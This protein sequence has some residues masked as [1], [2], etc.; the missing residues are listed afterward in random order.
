[1]L[2][3]LVNHS[4]P[5]VERVDLDDGTVTRLLRTA[6]GLV[7][8]TVAV[9]DDGVRILGGGDA[10]TTEIVREW[11]DLDTDIDAV[12]EAF[13]GD[14]VLGPL[15][16]ERPA[17]RVIGHP[18]AFEAAVQTVLGQQVSLAACRTFTGRLAAAYGAPGPGEL[19]AFPEAR[20]VADADLDQ[21]RAAVGIPLARARTV[22]AV[23]AAFADGL[24]VRRGEDAATVRSALLALPGIGPWTVDYL[25]LRVLR[26]PD[27]Y[28]VGDLVLRRALG[29]VTPAAASELGERWRPWRAY[30][31]MQLWT[32]DAFSRTSSA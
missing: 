31:T 19:L 3:S 30:A 11:F 8:V 27:A 5:G 29:G 16:R 7:P 24:R 25:A 21:L 22:I 20:V 1:M 32:A 28:P 15:V 23:A 10:E 4:V 17:V 2:R 9:L 26:D 6:S 13:A 14:A 18:D 12:G